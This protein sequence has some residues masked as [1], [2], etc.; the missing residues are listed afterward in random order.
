MIKKLRQIGEAIM[1]KLVPPI[2]LDAII[3]AV[4]RF[5][6]GAS[7]ED[8]SREIALKLPRRTLQRRLAQL[9]EQQR[10]IITGRGRASLYQQPSAKIAAVIGG[11]P[12]EQSI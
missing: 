10:L 8:I 7:L 1:A 12:G 5:S 11:V 2:E 6:E 9:V 4:F 3:Q